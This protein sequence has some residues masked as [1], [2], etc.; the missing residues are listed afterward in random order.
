MSRRILTIVLVCIGLLAVVSQ[1]R[2]EV[3]AVIRKAPDESQQ[4]GRYLLFASGTQ[5]LVHDYRLDTVTGTTWKLSRGKWKRI[6]D[7]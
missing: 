3:P 7:E 2:T 1:V 6:E 5:H 4:I